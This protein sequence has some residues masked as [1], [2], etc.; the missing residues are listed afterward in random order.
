MNIDPHDRLI[1][2]D[3]AFGRRPDVDGLADSASRR[4]SPAS[5]PIVQ[6]S[7]FTFPDLAALHA[8]FAAEHE[9]NLYSR[10]RNPTV[11]VLER[12]LASLERGEAGLCFGSGMA[13]VSAV[14]LGELRA[15]DHVLFV[16]DTYGPTLQLA[17]YLE[18]FEIEHDLQL[19]L[20]SEEIEAAIRP[21]TR[22]LWLESPGTMLFRIMDLRAV[23]ELARKRGIVTAIDNSW[24]TPLCQKPLM[25]GVDIVMHTCSKYIGGHSDVIAG[26]LVTSAERAERLF[27]S[28]YLLNGGILAPFDAWLLLRGLASLPVRLAQHEADALRVVEFLEAHPAVRRVHHPSIGEGR[29]LAGEQMS[30]FTG[31]LSFELVREGLEPVRRVIDALQHFRIGVSWG[32]VESLVITPN[33]GA[34]EARLAELGIPSG[35]IRISVGLE[36]AGLLIEDLAAA[37]DP[38]A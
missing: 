33:R 20:D 18:R 1:C 14:L 21:N 22:L 34:N 26:A 23:T 24:A 3:A 8:G 2:S 30:G 38:L 36:G 7:L 16:N 6:S 37:L 25:L 31:L 28:T 35:L 32:G 12:K 11:Q 4:P 19:D 9:T 29:R 27:S 15:G 5:Q 10:G 17:T 13:A